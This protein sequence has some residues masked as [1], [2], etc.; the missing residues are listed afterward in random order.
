MSLPHCT[1]TSTPSDFKDRP[2]RV[3][4]IRLVHRST[5]LPLDESLWRDDGSAFRH[6]II[7]RVKDVTGKTEYLVRWRE[8]GPIWETAE[9]FDDANDIVAYH[10]NTQTRSRKRRRWHVTRASA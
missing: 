4:L 5:D 9:A 7:H 1:L 8:G 10:K 2:V 3:E 6:I